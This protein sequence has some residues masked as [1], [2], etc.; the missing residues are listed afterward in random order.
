MRN[1]KWLLTVDDLGDPGR[2]P[3]IDWQDFDDGAVITD[4]GN[5]STTSDDELTVVT[6]NSSRTITLATS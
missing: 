3:P 6:I 1:S 5:S 2:T 4:A